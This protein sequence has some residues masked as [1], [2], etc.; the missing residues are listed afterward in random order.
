MAS[1]SPFPTSQ[2]W[3][4][5]MRVQI[6]GHSSVQSSSTFGSRKERKLI[7]ILGH[8]KIEQG[9]LLYPKIFPLIFLKTLQEKSLSCSSL[10]KSGS[11]KLSPKAVNPKLGFCVASRSLS[12]SGPKC[13]PLSQCILKI[14]RQISSLAE[15]VCSVNCSKVQKSIV[16]GKKS[17]VTQIH[18]NFNIFCQHSHFEIYLIIW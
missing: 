11:D 17:I 2:C 7:Y 13:S 16:L 3:Y 1:V 12:P 8:K 4:Y 6:S 18:S 9:Q 15:E 10:L 14:I 5:N